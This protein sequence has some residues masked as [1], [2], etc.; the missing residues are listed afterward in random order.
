MGL[1]RGIRAAHPLNKLISKSLI[2]GAIVE[3]KCMEKCHNIFLFLRNVIFEK[4][5]H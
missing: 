3:G 2:K 5:G 1:N 4:Y